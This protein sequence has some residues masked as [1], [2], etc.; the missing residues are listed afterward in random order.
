MLFFK[1]L[2]Y[3]TSADN[4]YAKSPN[5]EEK[6]RYKSVYKGKKYE[7]IIYKNKKEMGFYW[8]FYNTCL[9]ILSALTILPLIKQRRQLSKL[10]KQIQSGQ[11]FK[12]VLVANQKIRPK[13]KQEKEHKV[14]ENQDNQKVLKQEN[15]N[16]SL[17][18]ILKTG[19]KKKMKKKVHFEDQMDKNVLEKKEVTAKKNNHK[20]VKT[21]IKP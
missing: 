3:T 13:N 16:D 21:I 7:K 1:P 17:K 4:P 12:I 8:K 9:L 14:V 5:Y 15:K 19:K 20:K 18:G 2:L 6:K 11:E 10:W